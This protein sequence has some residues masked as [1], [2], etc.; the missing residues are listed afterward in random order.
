MGY[1][2]KHENT[3]AKKT[4]T[5]ISLCVLLG[6]TI[7]ITGAV[8]TNA[9]E[10]EDNYQK[11]AVEFVNQTQREDKT[12][13]LD[14][15]NNDYL[16]PRYQKETII[17]KGKYIVPEIESRNILYCEFLDEFYTKEGKP[18]AFIDTLDSEGNVLSTRLLMLD[19]LS[20]PIT[21]KLNEFIRIV[22]TKPYSEIIDKNLVVVMNEEL[23]KQELPSYQGDVVFK[24]R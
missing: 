8:V 15:E 4:I 24:K 20:D 1:N 19:K 18:I 2:R 23:S 16:L 6:L 22:N 11:A 12:L 13:Y 10:Q 14:E 17:S 3:G 7:G 5:T 21:I 9:K